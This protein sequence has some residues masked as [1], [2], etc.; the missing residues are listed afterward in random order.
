MYRYRSEGT[1]GGER[2]GLLEAGSRRPHLKRDLSTR[3]TFRNMQF[4][5]YYEVLGVPRDSNQD[6]IKQAYRRLARKFHPDVSEEPNAEERF[7]EL[8]EA[9]EVLK[10][11]EKREAYNRFGAD[12]KAGQEF[13]PPPDWDQGFEFRGGGFT[14]ASDF[15]EFFESLLFLL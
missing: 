12:W 13:R 4:K 10:D 14:D 11:P 6:D 8:Q 7:K 15:S 3:F 2:C 5:D 1:R 9:Y